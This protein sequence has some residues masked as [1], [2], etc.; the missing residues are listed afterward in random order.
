MNKTMEELKVIKIFEDRQ[1]RLSLSRQE[2][3]DILSMKKIL[4]K[5]MLFYKL[6]GVY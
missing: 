1:Q 6:M 3:N 2:A 4:A 5:T